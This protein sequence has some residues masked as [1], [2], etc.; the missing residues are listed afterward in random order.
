[1][2][3]TEFVKTRVAPDVKR[4]FEA[5]CVSRGT[6]PSE[7]LREF[8]ESVAA[9]QPGKTP[10]EPTVKSDKNSR[11]WKVVNAR[12]T[13]SEWQAAAPIIEAEAGSVTGWI[14]QLVR[15]RIVSGPQLRKDELLAVEKSTF[16]LRSIGRN[17][18]Q[19]VRAINDGKADRGQFSETYAKRLGDC[20][21]DSIKKLNALVVAS[22][23]RELG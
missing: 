5:E 21:A 6:A 16:Q 19:M 13:S 7:V 9:A 20:I 15:E 4:R 17:L 18:N 14:L 10:S 11:R 1:M 22:T 2:P 8:V 12:L 23:S 3:L